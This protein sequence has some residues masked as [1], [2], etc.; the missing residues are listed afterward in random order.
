[1]WDISDYC[2]SH[3]SC[4]SSGQT[5]PTV[6]KTPPP[7]KLSW[8]SHLLSIVSIDTAEEMGVVITASTD[9]TVRLWSVKGLYIGM[10][11]FTPGA[12]N[13]CEIDI[14]G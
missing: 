14:F 10:E 13:L 1:M 3:G 7:L 8:R 12:E 6:N 5:T 4:S 11:L 9:C 2:Q